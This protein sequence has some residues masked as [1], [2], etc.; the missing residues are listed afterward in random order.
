MESTK[1]ELGPRDDDGDPTV[2]G[3]FTITNNYTEKELAP[4]LAL[5]VMAQGEE[6]LSPGT[7]INTSPDGYDPLAS[8]K[9]MKAGETRTVM[10]T[11]KLKSQTDIV[12]V[13]GIDMF[14]ESNEI[15]PYFWDP[16]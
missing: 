2:I 13:F 5:P 9:K 15:E 3:T 6:L 11:A 7:F 14:D 16:K 10:I 1:I 4:L 12:T 8:Q